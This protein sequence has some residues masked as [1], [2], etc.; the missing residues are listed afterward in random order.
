[1]NAKLT[2][3]QTT[4]LKAAAARPAPVLAFRADVKKARATSGLR[5]VVVLRRPHKQHKYQ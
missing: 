5:L 2:A 1:M 4:V 3:T